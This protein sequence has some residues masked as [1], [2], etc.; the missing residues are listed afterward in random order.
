MPGF[1]REAAVGFIENKRRS[2]PK[3]KSFSCMNRQLPLNKRDQ[4]CQRVTSA[5]VIYLIR[6]LTLGSRLGQCL[7]ARSVLPATLIGR[8]PLAQR[9][10]L[11]LVSG[12]LRLQAATGAA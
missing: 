9:T 4:L 12:V 2:P 11:L 6:S 7:P 1:T 8:Q 10:Q 5:L 3:D